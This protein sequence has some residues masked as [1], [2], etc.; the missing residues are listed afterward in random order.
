MQCYGDGKPAGGDGGG[1]FGSILPLVFLGVLGYI[2]VRFFRRA[3]GYGTRDGSG[4]WGGRGDPDTEGVGLV[5]T[6]LPTG[7]RRARNFVSDMQVGRRRE[8]WG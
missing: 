3:Q 2:M 6:C 5:G 7:S 1:F 4:G 8:A